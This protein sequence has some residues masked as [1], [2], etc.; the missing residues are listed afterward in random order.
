MTNKLKTMRDAFIEAVYKKMLEN[1]RIFFVSA[2][3]GAPSLDALKQDFKDRFINV[4]IAEQ[5]LVN[6][7][8]GLGLEDYIVYAYAI[9]PF[10]TMRAYDQIRQNLSISAQVKPVNVNLVGVGTGLSYE[11]AGPSHHCFEDTSI[12]RLLP[13]FIVFSPSDSKL[14]SDFVDFS[15][16]IKMPKYIRFDS[17]PLPLIYDTVADLNF[18]DGFYELLKGERV[19]LVSTGYMTHTALKIAKE[20]DSVGVIDIFLLKGFNDKLLSETIKKYK[21]AVTI[22]EG[23]INNGGLDSL[24]SKIIRDYD[25]DV[26]TKSLGFNDKYV[27]NY[28]ER[29]Y[30]H[31]LNNLDEESIFKIIN[32]LN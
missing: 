32:K 16:N 17:A 14:A 22:E 30:L 7:A 8:A 26:K 27:F 31:K 21:Y 3:F 28:G 10:L 15:I 19:C 18:E 13:N 24:I 20:L 12:M 9:A 23:F 25:L 1:N 6:I 11:C 4:G 2:D 5:N 29:D